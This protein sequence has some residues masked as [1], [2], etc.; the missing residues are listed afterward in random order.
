MQ[1]VNKYISKNSEAP[2]W[3]MTDDGFL[4]CTARVAQEKILE[5]TN[6]E[7]KYHPDVCDKEFVNIFLPG[8]VLAD[9]ESLKSLE[10]VPVVAWEHT[11]ADPSVIKETSVGSVSGTPRI[12][13]DFLV[14]DLFITDEKTINQ[15]KNGAIGEISA[16]YYADTVFT[17]GEFN[18]EPFD[19]KLEALKYNHI[20]V[21]PVGH[22]RAGTDVK[23]INKSVVKEI[24]KM[25]ELQPL[26]RVQV[27]NS[28]K[29][30]NMDETSAG[31]YAEES[32]EMDEYDKNYNKEKA[33][34]D[35]EKTTNSQ[36]EESLRGR[37]KELE[38]EVAAYKQHME[39]MG[40]QNAIEQAARNM[41]M[42]QEDATSI[43]EN[44]E[45]QKPDDTP[46]DEVTTKEY[47][48]SVKKIHGE[49][50]HKSVLSAVGMDIKDMS[51]EALKGAWSVRKQIA[52][53]AP[54]KKVAGDRLVNKMITDPKPPNTRT[55]RERL[56]IK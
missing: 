10:G 56:G 52:N 20:A 48:N 34:W 6:E 13:G 28:K 54:S 27:R 35:V 37:I 21:I 31:I 33:D 5:Y 7:V 17:P 9:A 44:S 43:L 25:T 24:K 2:Q 3:R 46:M 36:L 32:N 38:G 49:N 45:L 4:R 53:K 51:A 39:A 29:F 40:D 22:G 23:I 16:A 50:L 14:C 42:E 11:W 15:I 8:D 1:Y 41:V 30:M 55:A 47:M 12:D 18:G 26:V 19:A